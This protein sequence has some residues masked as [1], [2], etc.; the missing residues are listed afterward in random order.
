M[1]EMITQA[2]KQTAPDDLWPCS[3]ASWCSVT[4]PQQGIRDCPRIQAS[5]RIY[6]E[7]LTAA[8]LDRDA[9]PGE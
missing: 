7:G 8:C 4:C 6:G 1:P 2:C 5:I 9:L 3:R